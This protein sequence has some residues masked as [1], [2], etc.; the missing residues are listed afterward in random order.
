MSDLEEAIQL[1]R[2]AITVTPEDHPD[3]A[4]QFNNLGIQLSDRYSRTGAM[5]DLEEAIQ[6]G[7]EAI[8]ATPEDHPDRAVQL[9]N[10]GSQLGDRYSRTGAMSDLEEAIQLGR[11]AITATPE[12]HPD[13]AVRLNNL[14]IQLNSRYLRTGAMS[15]LEEAIQLGREAIA[16]T[17][18]DHPDRAVQLNNLGIQ[19]KSRYSRTGAMSDLEEAIHY[20][21][22]ALDQQASLIT[23]RLAAGTQVLRSYA[24]ISKWQHAYKAA[25][26]TIPLV[27]KLTSRSLETT[28]KQYMLAQIVG[29][30]SDAAA[31]ALNAQQ[32][33][34]TALKLLEQGR[35]VLGASLEEVRIDI[36]PLQQ[37][38]PVLA[39]RFIQLRSIL[40]K[41][42]SRDNSAMPST[43]G[44]SWQVQAQ[45]RRDADKAFDKLITEIRQKPRFNDFLEA[46]SKTK[47]CLAAQKGPIVAI[48]VSQYRCDAILVLHNKI[49]CQPLPNLNSKE[50]E[51]KATRD[52]LGSPE[53][54]EWLWDN[55]MNP[56]L[57]PLGYTQSPSN[58]H[59]PHIWWISTGPL[60]KFPLHA[61]GYHHRKNFETMLDRVM[62]SY[63]PSVQA[64]IR[65]RSRPTSQP[66]IAHALLIAM[67]HTPNNA[68]LP[69]AAKEVDIL[70][71]LC[72][73][74]GLDP[75]LPKRRKQSIVSHLPQCRIFHFAGHGNTDDTDPLKSHLL[76][77]DGKD[78]PFT[79]ADL[80]EMNLRQHS[81]FLAYLSACG[82]GRIKDK[83]FIDESI[84]LISAF[85][86]A[87]FRHVIG[88]LWNVND[89]IC[90]DMARITYEKI[91]D[92][93]MEDEAVCR[94]LHHATRK[95][96]E[97]WLNVTSQARYGVNS[98][99]DG[100]ATSD[101]SN[102]CP[103]ND[104]LPRDVVLCDD[105]SDREDE[106]KRKGPL[107]W[108][109]YVHFGV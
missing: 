34:L 30:A 25:H 18:E 52:N 48:N 97:D 101:L 23:A 53:V 83:K 14:G 17:P 98:A 4:G 92:G 65:G 27:P 68:R 29:L 66:T 6:L 5:S 89:E 107:L 1:G 74:M 43:P 104:R 35:G 82:T 41:P 73:S 93:N 61:A 67:E 77:E 103:R 69:F 55:I 51:E 63:S 58:D 11:E 96:R 28:D 36:L 76:L 75:V 37:A 22:L 88:T 60:S 39:E 2:E 54:L 102:E 7:R 99:R 108:V 81:P 87:G 79:V 56:I 59:W 31:I 16:A 3:R 71:D 12:D 44:S 19:L 26:F 84:H 106:I 100:Y 57:E 9:S 42:I 24:A 72:K 80:L 86:L 8:A 105:D 78:D 38:H 45:Q 49:R 10:L 40:D 90:V 85:Q 20:H 91:A 13:R 109:P 64:I 21:Q 50:I 46:P 15:D 47:M 95:L 32:G 70:R 33:A 94:G 62:S